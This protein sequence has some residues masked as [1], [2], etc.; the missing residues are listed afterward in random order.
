MEVTISAKTFS[1]FFN[2][3]LL[4]QSSLNFNEDVFPT[5]EWECFYD[6]NNNICFLQPKDHFPL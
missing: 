6:D 4:L 2:D 1:Y 3:H 5:I